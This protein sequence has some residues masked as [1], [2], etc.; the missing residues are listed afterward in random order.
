MTWALNEDPKLIC[1]GTM[2]EEGQAYVAMSQDGKIVAMATD[3]NINVYNA[4][5][6]ELMDTLEAVH[7]G[8]ITLDSH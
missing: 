5:T 7:S 4:D 6:A 2:P 1:C 3:V 8:K